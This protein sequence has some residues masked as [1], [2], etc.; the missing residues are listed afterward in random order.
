[1]AREARRNFFTPLE[2][3]IMMY[4][5][6]LVWVG[7]DFNFPLIFGINK[8]Y[9]IKAS[10]PTFQLSPCFTSIII[11]IKFTLITFFL[12]LQSTFLFFGLQPT[13]LFFSQQ[14]TLFF[15]VYNPHFIFRSTI[16]IFLFGLQ[17][18][19]FFSV[20][21]LH[22]IFRSTIHII[23]FGLHRGGG[24]FNPRFLRR[25]GDIQP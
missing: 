9:Q 2:K 15:S 7:F 17:T 14:S 19:F 16:H 4:I 18:T 6:F 12:D 22:F 8:L 3:Y 10:F 24:V 25:G 20:Y 11:V 23:L 13:F 1:M 21:N 5:N